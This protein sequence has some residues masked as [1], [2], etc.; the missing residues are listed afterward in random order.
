MKNIID[1]IKSIFDTIKSFRFRRWGE[2]LVIP[3]VVFVLLRLVEDELLD[4]ELGWKIVVVV[5]LVWG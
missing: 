5:L 3:V 1:K 4:R 2:I